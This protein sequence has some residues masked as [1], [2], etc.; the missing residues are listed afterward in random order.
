MPPLA[1]AV[2]LAVLALSA[3]AASRQPPASV[4]E[5]VPAAVPAGVKPLT[6]EQEEDSA[7]A[8]A[9]A[10]LTEHSLRTGAVPEPS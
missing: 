3:C 9:A 6:V 8:P 10:G 2:L 4:G 7:A 1:V 5:E